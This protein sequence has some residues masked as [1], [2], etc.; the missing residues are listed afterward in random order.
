MNLGEVCTEICIDVM[1][2]CINNCKDD[3]CKRECARDEAI[4]VDGKLM[5]Q[6]L[7]DTLIEGFDE[8]FFVECPCHA[9]CYEGCNDC[10]NPICQCQVQ[11][12]NG[13]KPLK[14]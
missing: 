8:K 6:N 13:Q 11:G 5:S 2:D 9:E 12:S 3:D 4:C 7:C 10:E 1:I 14:R